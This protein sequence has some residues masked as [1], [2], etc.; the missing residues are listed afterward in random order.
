[1]A[2]HLVVVLPGIG[3]SVLS[4]RNSL[5]GIWTAGVW[6]IA[7]TVIHPP[8]LSLA[9]N[10]NLVASGLVRS[11]TI[12]GFTVVAG[13]EGLLTMLSTHGIV[14]PGDPRRPVPNADVV[15]VPYD[16]RRGIESAAEHLD[17]VVQSRLQHLTNRQKRSRVIVIAH[18]MG[19]LVARYWMGVMG[20]YKLCRALLT[21]GTPHRGAPKALDWLVNGVRL[22]DRRLSAL[23]ELLWDFP[24]VSQLLPTYRSIMDWTDQTVKPV[25]RY[26]DELPLGRLRQPAGLARQLHKEI[27]G[28]WLNM[29]GQRP[30]VTPYFGWSHA[31][32]DA[33]SWKDGRLTVEKRPN[34]WLGLRGWEDDLGD[35]TVPSYSALPSDLDNSIATLVRLPQMHTRLTAPKDL[36]QRIGRYEKY[37][38]PRHVHGR[39]EPD[40]PPT[41]GLDIEDVYAANQAIPVRVYIR[42]A[43]VDVSDAAVRARLIPRKPGT[44]SVS[45]TPLV[46][47]ASMEGH[48]VDLPPMPEGIYE[49]RVAARGIPGVVDLECACDVAVVATDAGER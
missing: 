24:S 14:D 48:T 34:T 1:M 12:L 42:G 10:P 41:I 15:A 30:E 27:E 28:S 18:S 49:L 16:W 26:V 40:H 43:E 7:R 25:P 11:T 13:Y 5:S 45:G 6:N 23:S 46:W 22:K 8:R 44:T 4:D 29:T 9:E 21:M 39:D 31:T 3:G 37:A 36:L 19:G 20:Q 2:E 35:G 33:A 38:P 17:R 47:D 32:L